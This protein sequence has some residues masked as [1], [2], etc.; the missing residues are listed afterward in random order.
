M[1]K[2]GIDALACLTATGECESLGDREAETVMATVVETVRG[3]K[4]VL[5]NTGKPS[6]KKTIEIS[7]RAAEL[8]VDGLLLLA[9]PFVRPSPEG[10]Y[11]HY[12]AV[13]KSVDLPIVIYDGGYARTGVEFPPEVIGKLGALDNIIGF[14][15]MSTDL[16]RFSRIIETAGKTMSVFTGWEQLLLP[17]LTL[18]GGGVVSVAG[19]IIPEKI[20]GIIQHFKAGRLEK[21]RDLHFAIQPLLRVL[22]SAPTP[23]VLK[24]M[25]DIVGLHGGLLRAPL[26]P[27][28]QAGI[29]LARKA[30]AEAGLIKV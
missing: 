20:A 22:Y 17:S 25:L 9:P 15:D 28:D 3:R 1:N 2:D 30:L 8:Q 19:H 11:Q 6:T 7:K 4:P 13:A 27:L 10:L 21:A 29:D 12:K 24:A 18:G 23:V 5:A 16:V 26:L 14:K